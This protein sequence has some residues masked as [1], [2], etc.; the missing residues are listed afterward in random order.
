VGGKYRNGCEINSVGGCVLDF[1]AQGRG[2]G[3]AVVN[4]G[5][6]IPVPQKTVSHGLR[7]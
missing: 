3:R 1:V 4:R 2:Q 7:N 6:N 5:V